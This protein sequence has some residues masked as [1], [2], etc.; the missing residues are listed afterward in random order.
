MNNLQNSGSY[1][2]GN[3][4]GA[5]L[6]LA[7]QRHRVLRNTYW[8]LAVALIPMAIGALIGVQL[9]FSFLRTNPIM[10]IIGMMVVLYGLMFAVSA[11]RNSSVGV[12]LL[13]LFTGVLGVFMGPLLQ[14][15]LTLKN[16][17]TLIAY[18]AGG[19]AAVFFSMAAIGAGTKRDLSGVGKF[20]TIGAIVLMVAVV[21][22][23]FLQLPVLSL[24]ISSLF[25]LFSSLVIMWELN[26]IVTGGETNYISATL[27]LVVQIYNIFTSLLHLL[28]SLGGNRD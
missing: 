8:L 11:N 21:A 9:S 25:I 7:T 27:T 24:V 22:N 1:A 13:L 14:M 20:L 12:V 4:A 26:N 23:I 16:G 3:S 28:I 2:F 6:D 19:T 10:G 18:A 15:A 5:G 17:G